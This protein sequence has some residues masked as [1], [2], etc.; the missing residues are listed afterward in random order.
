MEACGAGAGGEAEVTLGD[1]VVRVRAD[2]VAVVQ[3]NTWHRFVAAGTGRLRMVCI[4]ASDVMVQE[5]R[6]DA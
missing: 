3:A 2:E 5:N 4:H 6:A 1:D